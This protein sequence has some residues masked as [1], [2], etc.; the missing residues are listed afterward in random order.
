MKAETRIEK[1]RKKLNF[2][3]EKEGINSKRVRRLSIQIDYW[4][5]QFEKQKYPIFK[6]YEKNTKMFENYKK[7]YKAL[8]EFTKQ[9][10]DFLTIEEW[11]HFAKEHH[12][13]NHISIQYISGLDWHRL[14]GMVLVEK[15]KTNHKG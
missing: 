15:R 1:L 9:K 5:N 12:Y 8:E 11:N 4:L 13:L 2:C 10:K 6:N 14:R 3:I 7:S